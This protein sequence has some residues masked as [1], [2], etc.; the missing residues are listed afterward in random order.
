[1]PVYSF[2]RMGKPTPTWPKLLRG[3]LW[4]CEHGCIFVSILDF[5]AQK[6]FL[7]LMLGPS[8]FML[9]SLDLT[10]G[11]SLKV[12]PIVPSLRP[13]LGI[14]GAPKPIVTPWQAACK[15]RFT[16]QIPLKK[17]NKGSYQGLKESALANRTCLEAHGT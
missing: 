9:M 11:I 1:M 14:C 17:G 16:L 7:V 5:G 6:P 10:V 12:D 13:Q 4:T 8:P 2:G 15:Q 3:M